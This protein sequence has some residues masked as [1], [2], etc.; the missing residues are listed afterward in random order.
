MKQLNSILEQVRQ[1]YHPLRELRRLLPW[2]RWFG[3][4][5]FLVF[6]NDRHIGFR[7][8]VYALKNLPYLPG[9]ERMEPAVQ[10]VLTHC[11][12]RPQTRTFWDV[13]ANVGFYTWLALASR[14]HLRC[15]LV[16]PVPFNVKLLRK[17]IEAN[18]LS[19]CQVVQAAIGKSVGSEA[20]MVDEVSG[21]TSQLKSLYDRS[22]PGAMAKI[23]GLKKQIDVATTTLDWLVEDAGYVP[24]VVKL[25]VEHAELFLQEGAAALVAGGR[26]IFIFESHFDTVLDW[27]VENG[28]E[29]YKLDALKNYLAVPVSM[30]DSVL[31]TLAGHRY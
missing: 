13:G 19:Q 31:E 29:V 6:V 2:H 9:T 12:K 23:Y 24:D 25:D 8:F 11:V 16:E 20:M 1:K 10:R 30:V 7:Y 27:F 14:P 4:L 5:D 18:S 26:T 3:C 17:T 28:Y 21:A 22:S 15:L